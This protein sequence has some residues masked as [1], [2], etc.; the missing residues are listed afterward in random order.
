MRVDH[1]IVR[2][3]RPQL[4]SDDDTRKIIY[5]SARA[6][7]LAGG[8]ASTSM[9]NVACR[10]GI[11]TKTLYRLVPTKDDLFAG[12]MVSYLDRLVAKLRTDGE[13]EGEVGP[14][15]E[16][17]LIDCASFTLDDEVISLI[18]L[19]AAESD[20]F[21]KIAQ[22]FHEKGTVRVRMALAAW[23]RQQ[24]TKGLID[25]DDPAMTAGMLLGMMISE[26]QRAAIL[27]Q[28]RALGQRE[29]ASRAKACAKLFLDGCKSRR[30]GRG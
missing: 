5:D 14:A 1:R 29:I 11:S 12:M 23:L 8:Y 3:G 22:A 30:A 7:F 15:L 18:R 27:R 10:A 24:R 4:R 13:F 2:M 20:R 9:E 16:R 21:P 25:V 26:P 19:V 17:L 6:E 28:G